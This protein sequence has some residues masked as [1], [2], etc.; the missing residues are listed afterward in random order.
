MA[1]AHVDGEAESQH[2]QQDE[3]RGLPGQAARQRVA[4]PDRAGGVVLALAGGELLDPGSS[5]KRFVEDD[6]SEFVLTAP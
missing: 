4:D 3:R 1:Y 2:Y 5:H 6:G